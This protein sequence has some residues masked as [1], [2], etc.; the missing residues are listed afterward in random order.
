MMDLSV[1][2]CPKGN[3]DF[4]I[5]VSPLVSCAHWMEFWIGY[6]Y[7]YWVRLCVSHL[8]VFTHAAPDY[9]EIELIYFK[10][11]ATLIESV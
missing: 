5:G 10:S 9:L 7:S 1:S 4:L 2:L 8:E 6:R 3:Y 11:L